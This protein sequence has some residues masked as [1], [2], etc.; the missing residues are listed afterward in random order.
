VVFGGASAFP[1]FNHHQPFG[2]Q[3]VRLN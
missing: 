2:L 3:I 1:D